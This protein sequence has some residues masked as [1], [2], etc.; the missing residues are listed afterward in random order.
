MT[1]TS[2]YSTRMGIATGVMREDL[3][4]VIK[5]IDPVD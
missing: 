1:T 4:D 3:S 5:T 2:T